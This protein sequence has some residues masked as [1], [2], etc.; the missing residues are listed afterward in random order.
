[1]ERGGSQEGGKKMHDLPGRTVA[2]MYLKGETDK[3]GWVNE[4]CQIIKS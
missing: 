3:T 2:N 1:M 4:G